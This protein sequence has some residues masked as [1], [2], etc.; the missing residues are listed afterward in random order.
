MVEI[1][2]KTVDYLAKLVRIKIDESQIDSIVSD[3]RTIVSYVSQLKQ[4]DTEDIQPAKYVLFH[5]N[6][7]RKD[8]VKPSLPVEDV[9]KNAPEKAVNLFKVPKII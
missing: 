5:Y 9:F 6:V 2:R 7:S 1:D 3:L 8:M 4:I